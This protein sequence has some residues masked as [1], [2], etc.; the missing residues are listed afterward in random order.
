MDRYEFR[1]RGQLNPEWCDWF[2][3][4][5]AAYECDETVLRGPVRDQATL[6][7]IL[8]R[9]RDLGLTLISLHQEHE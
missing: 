6:Y 7:G 2:D 9:M 8:I 5:T 3:Q 1:V 4:L